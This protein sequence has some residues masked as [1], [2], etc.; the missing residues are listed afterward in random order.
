LRLNTRPAIVKK[1]A[2]AV[3][4]REIGPRPV[5]QP[6]RATVAFRLTESEAE[7]YGLGDRW[8]TAM[9]RRREIAARKAT[10]QTQMQ[11]AVLR[12]LAIAESER[13]SQRE[14][15]RKAGLSWGSFRRCRDGQADPV[16]W[17]PRLHAAASKL[18]TY[19]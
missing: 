17:L 10:Y 2:C 3:L 16:I 19:T 15:T 11:G 13:I 5:A 14:M 6:F 4:T 18:R 8:R 7:K 12:L 9:K 1:P